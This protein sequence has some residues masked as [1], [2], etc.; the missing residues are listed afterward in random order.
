MN[1]NILLNIPSISTQYELM[2]GETQPR[3]DDENDEINH[4]RGMYF[5]ASF[6]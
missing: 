2:I 6:Q 4:H 1:K 5:I 3:I